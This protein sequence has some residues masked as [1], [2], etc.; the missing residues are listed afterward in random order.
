LAPPSAHRSQDDSSWAWH[1]FGT[2]HFVR[3]VRCVQG[4]ERYLR[5]HEIPI[6]LD[7]HS[8]NYR[9]LA[10]LL[11]GTG[12][13]ISEATALCAWDLELE[14]DGGTVVV[15]RSRQ[16][17]QE[18][19]PNPAQ[20][21]REHIFLS[22]TEV[23][24]NLG[25]ALLFIRPARRSGHPKARLSPP[26]ATSRSTSPPPRSTTATSS[27]GGSPATPSQPNKRPS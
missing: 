22:A 19:D 27:T 21:L 5:L 17:G 24:S 2:S 8:E 23:G 12:V 7:S 1:I 16:D 15:C 13:R 3:R 25:S 14:D 26:A 18:V 10:A 9:P 11:I 20:T 6:Y 4:P